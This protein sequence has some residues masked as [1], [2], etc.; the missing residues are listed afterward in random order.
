M[1]RQALLRP[2]CDRKHLKREYLLPLVPLW[3]ISITQPPRCCCS[4]PRPFA[5]TLE[6]R[7]VVSS[8]HSSLVHWFDAINVLGSMREARIPRMSDELSMEKSAPVDN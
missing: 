6:M 5:E 4:P 7:G 3:P 1:T 8:R 2:P